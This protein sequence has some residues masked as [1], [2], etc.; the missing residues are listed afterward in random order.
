MSRGLGRYENGRVGVEFPLPHGVKA[1]KPECLFSLDGYSADLGDGDL[2]EPS[3]DS[4][5]E[6]EDDDEEYQ[7]DL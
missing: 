1:M 7:D 3:E 4:D 2:E 5:M 6:E